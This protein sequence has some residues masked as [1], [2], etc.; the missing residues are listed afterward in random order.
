M[1]DL[2]IFFPFKEFE[3]IYKNNLFDHRLAM[4]L[5]SSPIN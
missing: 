4:H 5:Q 1:I 3:I 2:E